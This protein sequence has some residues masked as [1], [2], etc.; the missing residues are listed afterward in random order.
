MLH[1]GS[2]AHYIIL[3]SGVLQVCNFCATDRGRNPHNAEIALLCVGYRGLC[4]TS[5]GQEVATAIEIV[6]DIAGLFREQVAVVI[7]RRF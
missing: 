4:I 6:D 7:H 1:Q 3:L 2:G 5:S